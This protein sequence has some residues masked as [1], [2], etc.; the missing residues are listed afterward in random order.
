MA[1]REGDRPMDIAFVV[2]T[3][4]ADVGLSETLV[5]GAVTGGSN[6]TLQLPSYAD[7]TEGKMYII[8]RAGNGGGS[9]FL[10]PATG[11]KIDGATG[12]KTIGSDS[13]QSAIIIVN[14]SLS[15]QGWAIVA[16]FG[17]G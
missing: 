4:N 6:V 16:E 5:V 17:A 11:E 10:A 3:A 2:R 13:E 9:L 1:F 8:K 14:T 7:A 12:N 15:Y